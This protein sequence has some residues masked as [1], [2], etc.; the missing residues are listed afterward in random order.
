[1]PAF[2]GS[3]DF[4]GIGGPFEGLGV[5]VGLFDEA[6]DGGLEI[7]DRAKDAAFETPSGQLGEVMHAP[8]I[9]E[10]MLPPDI[11]SPPTTL[12]QGKGLITSTLI[13]SVQVAVLAGPT[14]VAR[15]L[16]VVVP[17]L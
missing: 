17:A 4:V 2:D 13:E 7:D 12:N 5:I 11:T 16:I 15:E 8:E 10:L 6:V 1:M 3:D 9:G 14:I